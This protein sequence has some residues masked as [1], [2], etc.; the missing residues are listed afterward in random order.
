MVH[1]VIGANG[2]V[3]Q[4]AVAE[5]LAAHQPVR[6]FVRDVEAARQRYG[7]SVQVVQGDLNDPAS[8][9]GAMD[10]VGSI[11]L[12]APVSP[13]QV[14][15]QNG[16]I[17]AA[18]AAG[19]NPKVVKVSG[20]ATF[21]DSFVDSGRWHALTEAYLQAS[22]L[23]YTCLHPYFFM[24]NLGFQVAE[25]KKTGKL[26]SAVTQPVAMVDARDIAAV[27]ARAMLTPE[28]AQGQT[29][30]LTCG[31]AMTYADMAAVMSEVFE[32]HVEFELQTMAEV[33]ERLAASGQPDWHVQLLLQF[34]RAFDEGY[35]AKP[36]PAAEDILGRA[37][38]SLKDY[39]L[40]LDAPGAGTNPFP[41]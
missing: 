13:D 28:L 39:L 35:G 3:G 4:H 31:Q 26:K 7:D 19:L 15:Q 14:R 36:H 21:A 41:S 12:C 38:L 2:R 27:A 10:E 33:E 17:D 23:P 29:L 16:V 20:L 5:L 37:P 18:A 1:L 24:Q 34:N 40:S 8:L 25:V 32:Q 6:V 22:G 30:P 11:L 9:T